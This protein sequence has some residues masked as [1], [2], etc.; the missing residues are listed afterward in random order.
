MMN[1][2]MDMAKLE[3]GEMTLFYEWIELPALV[4]NLEKIFRELAQSR[5]INLTFDVQPNLTRV[6]ADPIRLR[7]ILYQLI[8][9]GI[10]LSP[11][12]GGV[13]VTIQKQSQQSALVLT[14][15]DSG[16]RVSEHIPDALSEDFDF[17]TSAQ[18]SHGLG[19]GVA[20]A[21]QLIELHGGN[22]TFDSTPGLGYLFTV[23]LPL[24]H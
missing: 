16:Q 20:L 3:S 1:T 8:K 22:L 7:Q 9:H 10:Q 17:H 23:T 6:L 12:H 11:T 4:T 15:K 5:E 13:E 19:H 2:T 14:I 18:M 21:K 24:P